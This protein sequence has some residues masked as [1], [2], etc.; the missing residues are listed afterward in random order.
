MALVA[1]AGFTYTF[2]IFL[3]RAAEAY[4][5]LVMATR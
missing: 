4:L 5:Y 3:L 2:A 1:Y